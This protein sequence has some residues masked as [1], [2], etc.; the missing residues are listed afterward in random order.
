VAWVYEQFQIDCCRETLRKLLKRLGFAWKK[1]HKLLNK[2][3]PTKRADFLVRL[4]G[5]LTDV[6]HQRCLLI[7]IDEAHIHLDTDVGYGWGISGERFWVS[8]CSPGRA[9][10]SFYGVYLFNLAQVRMFAYDKAEQGNTMDVLRHLRQEFPDIPIKLVWDGASY[11]RAQA[12]EAMAK[13]LDIGL[14]PLPA[15]SPDFMPVEHL[16]RWLREEVTYH[17]CYATKE[18]LIQRVELFTHQI[19]EVPLAIADCLWVKN[20]IDPEEE[21]LR[22]ST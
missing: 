17:T 9:K 18:E 5:L 20:H 2:A 21:K 16:W 13:V 4:Q 15:Y 11:H 10:V 1:S 14:E 12:V 22:F 19:N 3:N 8:S 7:Y 6:M